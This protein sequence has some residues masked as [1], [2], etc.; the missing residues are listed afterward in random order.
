LLI[1]AE[2]PRVTPAAAAERSAS[3]GH[4]CGMI[5]VIIENHNDNERNA[6]RHFRNS[7]VILEFP[8]GFSAY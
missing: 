1:D 8:M 7:A 6:S 3:R 4:S 2:I 5:D